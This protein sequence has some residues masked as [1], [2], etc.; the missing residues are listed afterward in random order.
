MNLNKTKI[1]ATVGPACS[2]RSM[3]SK[4]I[5]SGVDV[6]RINFSHATHSEV[7]KIVSHIK[8]LRQEHNKHVTILGDLQG[9]KIRT[10]KVI[11]GCILKKGNQIVFTL[12]LIH[13]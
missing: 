5:S 13:I 8:Y 11:E 10:G 2:S 6:F 3:L 12:S 9:P 1:I 7:K 4:L